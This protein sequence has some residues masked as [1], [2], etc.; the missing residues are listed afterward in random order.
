MPQSIQEVKIASTTLK[1]RK[2]QRLG[3]DVRQ[4]IFGRDK[5]DL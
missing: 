1:K 4:L 2:R 5:L 3:E